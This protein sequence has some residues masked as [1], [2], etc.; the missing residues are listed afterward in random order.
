MTTTTKRPAGGDAPTID[1]AWGV[2]IY[3]HGL[4]DHMRVQ[5]R[6]IYRGQSVRMH[7]G[8]PWLLVTGCTPEALRGDGRPIRLTFDQPF[9]SSGQRTSLFA[10]H[11]LFDPCTSAVLAVS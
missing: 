7:P 9:S 6:D 10:P 11:A 1:P 4:P 8:E 3:R 5:A 2:A